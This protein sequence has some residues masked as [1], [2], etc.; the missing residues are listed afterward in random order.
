[1]N[2]FLATTY[3]PFLGPLYTL[4][5]R[6]IQSWQYSMKTAIVIELRDL[7]SLLSGCETGPHG[8]GAAREHEHVSGVTDGS[9]SHSALGWMMAIMVA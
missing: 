3:K 7:L 4:P 1:M 8:L 2:K 9:F 6:T 5:V